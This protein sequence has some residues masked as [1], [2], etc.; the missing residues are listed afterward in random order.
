MRIKLD[1]P[2]MPCEIAKFTSGICNLADVHSV[3]THI[4]TDSRLVEKG[5]LFIPIKGNRFDGK[6]FVNEAL[7]RGAIA[8]S[9]RVTDKGILVKNNDGVLLKIAEGY[10]RKLQAL[11]HTVAITGSVGKST[12]KEFI[13]KI[14]DR[15]F[16]VHA[17]EG[18]FNNTVGVPLT[19][20]SSP[21]NTEIL[22]AETGM[23]HYGEL[24]LLSECLKPDAAVITNIG[25]AH[26]G[27]FGSR[28]NI[29]KAKK[30]IIDKNTRVVFI[31]YD[32]PLLSDIPNSVKVS[33]NDPLSDIYLSTASVS[34]DGSAGTFY[35]NGDSLFSFSMG[36][37]GRHIMECLAF[38]VAVCDYLNM[39]QKLI[40]SGIESLSSK[41]I[42][43]GYI[44]FKNF[45]VYN[46]SYN[47]SPEALRSA[48]ELIALDKSKVKSALIGDML[49]L[50][51]KTEALHFE[52]GMLAAKSGIKKL[53]L[54]G[55]YSPFVME[56]ALSYG[57]PREDIL[58]NTDTTAPEITA[59]QI[60][61]NYTPDELILFKA[62]HSLKLNRV[63]E[64]IRIL[65]G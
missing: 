53:Y 23:N 13:R 57:M 64:Y 24:A 45:S 38:A 35:K 61:E 46:D 26:I 44:H 33:L 5:D 63:C 17:N 60:M 52:A 40:K 14:T 58:I 51:V 15:C 31:P 10:K 65:E 49:E 30:E 42:R 54:F 16:N 43:Q 4:T 8:I 2:L 22:I 39:D 1:I 62:S 41:D 34:A 50:G 21:I 3:I 47:S 59:K 37:P 7:R 55:V 11:K 18:N 6:N 32:E 27:N 9:E 19:V 25:N 48:F 20:L 29:A 36:I 28:E 56:G 12:T